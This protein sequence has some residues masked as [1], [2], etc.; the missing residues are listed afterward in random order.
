M[1][2][3]NINPYLAMA[4]PILLLLLCFFYVFH[5]VDIG[6]EKSKSFCADKEG[7]INLTEQNHSIFCSEVLNC[8]NRENPCMLEIGEVV[9]KK[10]GE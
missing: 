6:I 1:N 4:I 9:E 5:N 3:K 10:L 2:E 8:S 7:L